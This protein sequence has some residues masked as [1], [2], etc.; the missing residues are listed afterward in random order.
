MD[1]LSRLNV[2][3]CYGARACLSQC[4][5]YESQ[6]PNS[7]ILENA[8]T[9]DFSGKDYWVDTSNSLQLLPK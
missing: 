8:E 9:Y 2:V 6:V 7:A 5:A 4:V 1:Q 3:L